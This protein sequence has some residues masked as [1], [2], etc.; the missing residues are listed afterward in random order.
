[1]IW[2]AWVIATAAAL[3]WAVGLVLDHGAWTPFWGVAGASMACAGWLGGHDRARAVGG[4]VVVACTLQVALHGNGQAWPW[5]WWEPVQSWPVICAAAWAGAAMWWRRRSAA[6]TA[7]FSVG[8][9]AYT[10]AF[11]FQGAAETFLLAAE[12]SLAGA[13]AAALGGSNGRNSN[14]HGGR[15]G[16]Y[17]WRV[18]HMAGARIYPIMRPISARHGIASGA[19]RERHRPPHPVD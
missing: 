9:M 2:A 6:V 5:P 16:R 10:G 17:S 18:A 8:A 11:Y 13:M 14:D 12:V 7:C 15:R 4:L 19:D 1:M 3:A